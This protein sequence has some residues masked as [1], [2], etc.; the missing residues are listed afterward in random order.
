M[1]NVSAQAQKSVKEIVD[2]AKE[3]SEKLISDK[4]N[5]EEVELTG[6]GRYWIV[7]LSYTTLVK[8]YFSLGVPTARKDY[9]KFKI[10][11]HTGEVTSMKIAKPGE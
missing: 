5:L 9:K 10:N 1:A 11:A 2:I 6:D 8:D 4:G 3:Y 7:T